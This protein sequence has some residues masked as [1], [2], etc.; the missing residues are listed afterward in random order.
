MDQTEYGVLL[1]FCCNRIYPPYYNKNERDCFRRSTKS[2]VVKEGV[3]FYR[4]KE[5]GELSGDLKNTLEYLE[6][7]DNVIG[8][9]R[10]GQ[11]KRS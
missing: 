11:T 2:F 4:D 1:A 6:L 10:E 8:C 5:G 9:D 7:T 3:L